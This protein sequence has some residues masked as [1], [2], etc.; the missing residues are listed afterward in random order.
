MKEPLLCQNFVFLKEG[1]THRLSW[2]PN[3][4]L[5]AAP[6]NTG[7]IHIWDLTG[8]EQVAIPAHKGEIFNVAWSPDSKHLA[9]CSESQVALFN[10][11]TLQVEVL[12][13]LPS[14]PWFDLSWSS[15]GILALASSTGQ[16]LLYDM[17]KSK[18]VKLIEA[19]TSLNRV[20]WNPK[21]TLLAVCGDAKTSIWSENGDRITHLDLSEQTRHCAWSPTGELFT[22]AHKDGVRVW[23]TENWSQASYIDEDEVRGLSFSQDGQLLSALSKEG[24]LKILKTCDWSIV[25]EIQ[26]ATCSLWQTQDFHP[27]ENKLAV[28]DKNGRHITIWEYRPDLLKANRTAENAPQKCD[29][30]PPLSFPNTPI[31]PAHL[32]WSYDPITG[33]LSRGE[34]S[35]NLTRQQLKAF[36]LLERA[37]IKDPKQ[38]LTPRE[39]ERSIDGRFRQL[40]AGKKGFTKKLA[41]LGLSIEGGSN[42]N[43][44]YRLVDLRS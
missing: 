14:E 4:T 12:E 32:P 36:I 6:S 35:V 27:S 39:I 31:R 22:T 38:R 40:L 30:C 33:D 29:S 41:D 5:L 21:G 23:S 37:F 44:G 13:N 7:L 24:R 8:E 1:L 28:P 26:T 20:S 3:G 43:P 2:S 16:L 18:S 17:E 10:F 34:Q 15:S 9:S 25:A 19:E 42:L 11:F